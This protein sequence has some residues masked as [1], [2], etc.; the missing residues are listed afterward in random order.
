MNHSD[1]QFIKASIVDSLYEL[2]DVAYENKIVFDL[3][4]DMKFVS[5][6]AENPLQGQQIF[7]ISGFSFET[8]GYDEESISFRYGDNNNAEWAVEI[9]LERI[10]AIGFQGSMVLLNPFYAVD[11]N[12]EDE[13]YKSLPDSLEKSMQM[14]KSNSQNKSLFKRSVTADDIPPVA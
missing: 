8:F 2:I 7:N 9:P 4:L 3:L 11:L 6:S 1:I 12:L 5:T 10:L 14:F 13:S